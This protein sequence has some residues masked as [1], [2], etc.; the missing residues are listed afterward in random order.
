MRQNIP[1]DKNDI[2]AFV[3]DGLKEFLVAFYSAMDI[4]YKKT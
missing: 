4:R 3:R 1:A 2:G